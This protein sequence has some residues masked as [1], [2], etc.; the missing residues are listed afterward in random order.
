M[1][2]IILTL[3]SLILITGLMACSSNSNKKEKKEKK[4]GT[5]NVIVKTEIPS[6]KV[7]KNEKTGQY[8]LGYNF[9]EGETIKYRLYTISNSTRNVVADT[10]FKNIFS[11]TIVRV[12]Q[13]KTKKLNDDN[14]ADIQ[15]TLLSASVDAD[16]NGKKIKYK[17]GEKLD[18][19]DARRFYEFESTLNNPFT[20]KVDSHGK[21]LEVS[22]VG[23]ILNKMIKI[24]GIVDT[25]SAATKAKIKDNLKENLILPLMKQII[26]E[27]PDKQIELGSKWDKKLQPSR[28]MVFTFNYTNHYKVNNIQKSANDMIA[29]IDGYATTDVQGKTKFSNKGINYNFT[30]PVSTANG[31]IFFN[32]TRNLVQKSH[33][34]T[35]VE[36]SYSMDVPMGTAVKHG[37]AKEITI[38]EN[39]LEL[40]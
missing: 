22:K 9:K 29:V 21:I 2:K 24:S 39:T 34:K 18:S 13:L 20:I 14:T 23:N 30:K 16:M 35:R 4:T 25:L 38:N 19:V 1:K 28:Y 36:V 7:N 31:K 5:S 12:V 11:Q 27:F 37:S 33:T 32:L 26:R 3:L 17:S 10:T 6:S 15:C 40:L 8:S